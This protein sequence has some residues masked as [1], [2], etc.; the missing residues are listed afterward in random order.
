MPDS[1]SH[2]DAQGR[3]QMV[4][5][6]EKPD[7]QRLAIAEGFIRMRAETVALIRSDGFT[8]G[9]V[10]TVAKVAGILAAKQTAALI[11]MCHPLLLMDVRLDLETEEHGVAIRGAVT[12]FGKTGAEMEALTAVTV[13]GLTVYD[14]CKAADK[15]MVLEGVRLVKK[16]GGKSDWTAQPSGE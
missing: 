1:L 14:M 16:Q 9:D 5:V 7:T 15:E 10:L 8:K 12:T 13:A 4:D 2:V 3:A 11:P 6:S